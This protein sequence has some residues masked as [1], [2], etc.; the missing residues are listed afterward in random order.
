MDNEALTAKEARQLRGLVLTLVYLNQKRQG[1]HLTS[2]VILGTLTREG[3][4]FSR[5]D[6]LT[7]IQD[8]RDRDLLRYQQMRDDDQRMFIF[9]IEIT[10]R[11]RDLH[12]GIISDPAVLTQ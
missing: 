1:A 10:A 2:T 4:Q 9:Q 7:V 8:L 12:D 5:K 6:V 11:G 3:Y